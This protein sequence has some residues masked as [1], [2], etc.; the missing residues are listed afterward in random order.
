VSEKR[1]NWQPISALSLIGSM[2]DSLLDEM[3]NHYA[4]LQ[5]CRLKP[6]VLDNDTVA[7][8]SRSIPHRPMMSSFLRRSSTGGE[9]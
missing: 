5:A 4:N 6:H 2:I 9:T 3:E 8:S 1:A 7:A